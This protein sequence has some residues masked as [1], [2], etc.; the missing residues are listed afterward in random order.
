[1]NEEERETLIYNGRQLAG[2]IYKYANRK[3]GHFGKTLKADIAQAI[4][5]YKKDH[6]IEDVNLMVQGMYDKF[7]DIREFLPQLYILGIMNSENAEEKKRDL[8]KKV[9]TG[10]ED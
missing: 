10:E 9:L 2:A 5:Y 7:G 4:E 8:I 3:S 6:P 1:M